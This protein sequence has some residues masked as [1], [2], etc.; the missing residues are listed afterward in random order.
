MFHFFSWLSNGSLSGYILRFVHF[1]VGSYL[2]CFCLLVIVD[3]AAVNV[4]VQVSG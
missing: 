1:S 3:N 2:D 4:S